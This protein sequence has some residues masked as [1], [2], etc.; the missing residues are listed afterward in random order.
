[1]IMIVVCI[2]L[3]HC[4]LAMTSVVFKGLLSERCFEWT[5]ED[6]LLHL[7]CISVTC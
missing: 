2:H 6:I 7:N 3:I 1:M 5:S 4:K